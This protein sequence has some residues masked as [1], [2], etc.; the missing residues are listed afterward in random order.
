MLLGVPTVCSDVG[1]V[2]SIFH[3]EDGILYPVNDVQAL[4]DAVCRMFAGGERVENYTKNAREH[5]RESHD[6]EKNY[7]RLME[8]YQS[9]NE[10][11][12]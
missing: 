9:I 6:P 7:G 10:N 8:I 1:G 4:A 11:M 3:G 12:K 2:S 5:A